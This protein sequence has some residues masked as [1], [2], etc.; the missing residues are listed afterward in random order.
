[1]LGRQ[2]ACVCVSVDNSYGIVRI[3]STSIPVHLIGYTDLSLFH[4][5]S[6]GFWGRLIFGVDLY[7]GKCSIYTCIDIS[8][9]D[10]R[11]YY[12]RKNP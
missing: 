11:T 8:C 9:R 12:T 6:G 5:L 10:K 4:E 3:M 1:M 2:A 7:S